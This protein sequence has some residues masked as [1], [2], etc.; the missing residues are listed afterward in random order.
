MII[1]PDPNTYAVSDYIYKPDI[2]GQELIDKLNILVCH[3]MRWSGLFHVWDNYPHEL[4]YEGLITKLAWGM[5][6]PL[7]DTDNRFIR[8]LIETCGFDL[9]P[10]ATYR[11]DNPPQGKW[12]D[13]PFG[14]GFKNDIPTHYKMACE[15]ILKASNAEL[16][17]D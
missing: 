16:L 11:R 9:I 6:I 7:F 2:D 15:L 1:K 12:D 10:Y 13:C 17:R 4:V 5:S 8:V 14:V 3:E